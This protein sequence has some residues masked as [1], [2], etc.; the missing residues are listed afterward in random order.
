M[1]S[2]PALATHAINGDADGE[3]ADPGRHLAG[4]EFRCGA[5]D[6]ATRGDIVNLSH[7]LHGLARLVNGGVDVLAL[8]VDYDQESDTLASQWA[9]FGERWLTCTSNDCAPVEGQ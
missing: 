3:A 6:N 5:P 8:Y 1:C 7:S 9:Q 4:G 2:L